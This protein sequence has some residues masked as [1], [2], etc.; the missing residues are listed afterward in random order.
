MSVFRVQR[1][2][3]PSLA[4][5]LDLPE[6]DARAAVFMIHGH[7]E[8]RGCYQEVAA[9]WRARGYAVARFDLRG[10]GQSGGQRS[11]INHFDDYLR[12]A[13]AVL[14]E[15]D[16]QSR[17]QNLGEPIVFAHSLGGL[18]AIQLVLSARSQFRALAMT[19]PYLALAKEVSPVLQ[20]IG[21]TMSHSWP[22]FSLNSPVK[23]R[24]LTHDPQ[25]IAQ[26]DADALRTSAVT[27]RFFTEVERAQALTLRSAGDFTTPLFCLAAGDDHVV[28]TAAIERWFAAVASRDKQ[29]KV[30]AGGYHEL[31]NEPERAQYIAALA[32]HFDGWTSTAVHP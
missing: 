27:A 29:L 22:T 16:R 6:D 23:S 25:K 15:L 3:E 17:W 21:R 20:W 32:D 2:G 24:V 30:V 9:A 5:T 14:A 8:H 7:G 28:S 10:H 31:L 18:I 26:C 4:C 11:H 13:H 19:S 1:P 12:D